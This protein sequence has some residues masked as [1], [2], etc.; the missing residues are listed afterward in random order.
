MVYFRYPCNHAI[1][2]TSCSAIQ[3]CF[4][5]T[6]LLPHTA[7]PIE[8]LQ[9]AKKRTKTVP[10][11]KPMPYIPYTS[12]SIGLLG[13]EE[14]ELEELSIR[15]HYGC[16]ELTHDLGEPFV[17]S[18]CLGIEPAVELEESQAARFR[19]RNPE[20]QVARFEIARLASEG[21]ELRY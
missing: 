7:I 12:S 21:F 15:F 10:F 17:V 3:S 18:L 20:A 6:V 2:C 5:K 11:I 19:W 4:I 14:L 13:N 1:P 9:Q 16:L 8:Q